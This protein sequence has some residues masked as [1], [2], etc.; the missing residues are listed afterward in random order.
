MWIALGL[1]AGISA[2]AYLPL[3]H[4]FGYFNDDWY[5]MYDVRVH[6]VQFFHDIFSSDRP[7]RAYLMIPMYSLFGL[8]PLPYNISAYLFRLLGGVSFFWILRILW[9]DRKIFTLTAALFFT[10]YPGFLSQHN[11]ID[12]QSHIWSLF[13]ALLSVALTLKSILATSRQTKVLFAVASVLSGWVYL[14]QMEYFIGIEVFRLACVV[15]LVWRQQGYAF[16]QKVRNAFL[17]WLPFVSIPAGFLFWRIFLFQAERKATDIGSQLGQLFASPLTGLWW[18]TYLVQDVFN[19]LLAPWVLPLSLYVFPMRLQNQ[20]IGFGLALMGAVLFVWGSRWVWEDESETLAGS[21]PR[22]MREQVWVGIVG[23]IGGLAPVIAANR[24]IILP[25]YSRYTLIASVG[26]AILLSAFLQQISSRQVRVLVASMMIAIGVLTHY[27]NSVKAA[28]ESEVIR[29][30][31]WQVAWRAPQIESGTTLSVTYPNVA[32]QEDYFIW[33]AA[34]HIY[35]PELKS[36]DELQVDLAGIVLNKYTIS[37]IIVG[38]SGDLFYKRGGI[39]V[40]NEYDNVLVITQASAN[41]CVRVLDG[42]SPDLSVNDLQRVMLIAPYSKLDSVKTVGESPVPPSVIFGNEPSREWCYYYQKADLAQ[43]QGNWDKVVSLYEQAM[44]DGY[45]PNDQ[46]EL[47]PFLQAY[48][49]VG[50]RKAVKELSTRINTDVFYSDQACRA[51]VQM[52]ER[53]YPLSLEMQSYVDELF[54][55]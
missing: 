42:I 23:L 9:P 40:V 10:I 17:K 45:R 13:F 25:D 44:K 34:N 27:G 12:Y 26:G 33:G 39:L 50:N 22:E 4:K 54:C 18:L 47:M 11:A 35:Y 55:K 43:Q 21:G 6:G 30:F 7:A 29:N 24:H 20:L 53:G 15:L 37:R 8:N 19:V 38:R 51:L 16:I 3:V 41:S 49:Y 1:L 2:L 14:S 28:T 52:A 36:E 31:W 32:I 46:I 5:L 48:A